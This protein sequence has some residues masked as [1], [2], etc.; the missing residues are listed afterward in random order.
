MIIVKLVGG[1]GNQ[2]FQYAAARRFSYINNTQLL[3]DLSWFNESGQ[4]ANRKYELGV[5]NITGEI[6]SSSDVTALKLK[7]PKSFWSRLSNLLIKG[8]IDN[9]P[10]H[11]IEKNYSFDSAILSLHGN[12]YLD[13]YWQSGKYFIDIEQIIRREFS[14]KTGPPESNQRTLDKITSSESIALHI[15]RGDYVTL[16]ETNAY[17]GVCPLEYYRLAANNIAN[18]L[19]K[20]VFLVFS[21]DIEWA[22]ENLDLQ[23]ET[24]FIDH[25]APEQGCDDLR[26]MSLCK[27]HIIANSSFSWWGA[28]LNQNP[29][30][31]VIAP[32]KW[33]N[34]MSIDTKDLIPYK[35]VRL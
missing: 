19:N 31:I 28:W 21:D 17:H 16:A 32:Q 23:Y 4:V 33:F 12:V 11:I 3:L 8:N 34:D 25:N 18:Q 7:E 2:M 5:F 9:N 22:K 27:H 14:F 20:P 26:L 35:W 24:D 1:I 13:G 10:T 6:A 29:V 15:R 30:K